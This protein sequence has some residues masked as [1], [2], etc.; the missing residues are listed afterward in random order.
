MIECR[1]PVQPPE[2]RAGWLPHPRSP[3]SPVHFIKLSDTSRSSTLTWEGGPEC[4]RCWLKFHTAPLFHAGCWSAHTRPS[5]FLRVT[6]GTEGSRRC[7]RTSEGE[8]RP[9]WK[10]SKAA[11]ERKVLQLGPSP[12]P[13]TANKWYHRVGGGVRWIESDRLQSLLE[14]SKCFW[15]SIKS[16]Q[17]GSSAVNWH[18]TEHYYCD[19]LILSH[20]RLSPTQYI[21]IKNTEIQ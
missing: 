14:C 5:F 12:S 19:V 11:A 15:Q 13:F 21:R 18:T 20:E 9:A 6:E 17:G 2:V 8:R 7:G 10:W 1:C 3:H 4:D 16:R